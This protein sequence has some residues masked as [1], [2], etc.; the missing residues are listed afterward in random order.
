MKIIITSSGKTLDSE[1]SEVFGRCPV[2]ILADTE[3][4]EFTAFDNT[5][6]SARGG[7]GIQSA[8]FVVDQGAEAILNGNIGPKALSVIKAAGLP[9]YVQE[10]KT[11]AEVIDNFKAGKLQKLDA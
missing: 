11:A 4:G 3:T 9:I 1:I 10:G 2:F 5:A 6:V 8:Q 7:A